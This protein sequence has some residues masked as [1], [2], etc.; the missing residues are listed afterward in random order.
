LTLLGEAADISADTEYAKYLWKKAA[1]LGNPHAMYY[2]AKGGIRGEVQLPIKDPEVVGVLHQSARLGSLNSY[3]LLEENYVKSSLS[4]E[5]ITRTCCPPEL[6][7]EKYYDCIILHEDH[8]S[9]ED[10]LLDYWYESACKGNVI[11]QIE[12]AAA[13]H[14]DFQKNAAWKIFDNLIH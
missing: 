1:N 8:D 6:W 11:A 13:L 9:Y 12:M 4:V 7:E 14:W 10:I 3:K 5:V 2:L